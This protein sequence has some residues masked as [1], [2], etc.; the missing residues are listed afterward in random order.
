MAIPIPDLSIWKRL[1]YLSAIDP[2]TGA[3]NADVRDEAAYANPDQVAR[4][5]ETSIDVST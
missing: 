1:P 3:M 4:F 5:S 2:Q